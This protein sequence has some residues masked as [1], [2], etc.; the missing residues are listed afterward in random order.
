METIFIIASTVMFLF[1]AA[2]WSRKTIQDSAI[3]LILWV[4]AIMGSLLILERSGYVV[5][6]NKTGVPKT[7]N[8][9]GEK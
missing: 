7:V 4:L 8:R 9:V 6:I 2:I 3:K 1:L 5:N